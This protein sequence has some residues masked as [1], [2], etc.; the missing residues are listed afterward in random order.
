MNK[1]LLAFIIALLFAGCGLRDNEK[2]SELK[3]GDVVFVDE[4]F[5]GVTERSVCRNMPDDKV[6]EVKHYLNGGE[7]KETYTYDTFSDIWTVT[8]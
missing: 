8:K 7:T 4:Y 6:I 2:I 5:R 3:E 1:Y